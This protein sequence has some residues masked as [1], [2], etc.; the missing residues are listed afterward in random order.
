M[1]WLAV[2]VQALD[3]VGTHRWGRGHWEEEKETHNPE[4]PLCYR[5]AQSRK[6]HT[7]LIQKVRAL[8]LG[9]TIMCCKSRG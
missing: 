3:G 8:W 4:H 6:V 2:G 7:F 9:V 1:A 5:H